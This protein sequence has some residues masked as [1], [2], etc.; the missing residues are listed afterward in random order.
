MSKDKGKKDQEFDDSHFA[1]HE[2]EFF[3]KGEVMH[4]PDDPN[5]PQ[6]IL[7]EE[8]PP[9]SDEDLQAQRSEYL[10][11]SSGRSSQ[12]E[13]Y[14]EEDED[15]DR[16]PFGYEPTNPGKAIT[17]IKAAAA[18][19]LVQQK[20]TDDDAIYLSIDTPRDVPATPE[21]PKLDNYSEGTKTNFVYAGLLNKITEIAKGYD[22]KLFFFYAKDLQA[23]PKKKCAIQEDGSEDVVTFVAKQLFMDPDPRI[24]Q[25][26]F[27]VD[28]WSLEDLKEYVHAEQ[29]KG[30]ALNDFITFCI[31]SEIE[32]LTQN[33]GQLENCINEIIEK[34]LS[35]LLRDMTEKMEK[36]DYELTERDQ[37]NIKKLIINIT[38]YPSLT[39]FLTYAVKQKNPVI[40]FFIEAVL[41]QRHEKKVAQK[42]SEFISTKFLNEF[43]ALFDAIEK[44]RKENGN[45]N[46]R[47]KT[48]PGI[49][50]KQV[51][52]GK[53][54]ATVPMAINPFNTNGIN[55]GGIIENPTTGSATTAQNE[56]RVIVDLGEEETSVP[57]EHVPETAQD[58]APAV[59]PEPVAEEPVAPAADP[60]PAAEEPVAPAADPE[61]VV[62]EVPAINPPQPAAKDK[63]VILSREVSSEIQLPS[64]MD[65]PDDLKVE[66]NNKFMKIAAYVS[67]A[68]IL[69][70]GGVLLSRKSREQKDKD[71]R[72]Q[73]AQKSPADAR[74]EIRQPVL[75]AL[76][77][78]VLPQTPDASVPQNASITPPTRPKE[79]QTP[80]PPE[81]TKV[82]LDLTKENLSLIAQTKEGRARLRKL[83]LDE[84]GMTKI[85]PQNFPLYNSFRLFYIYTPEDIPEGQNLYINGKKLAFSDN[86]WKDA[87]TGKKVY[88]YTNNLLEV[89]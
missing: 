63:G 74:V 18:E 72:P 56:S 22:G 46:K 65:E 68:V 34:K 62:A 79:D 27:P 66:R 64:L 44:R 45:G 31:Y 40:L 1:T 38:D 25:E 39:K 50:P 80:L 43:I 87:A 41:N 10:N 83:S 12:A 89:K 81:D 47:G 82:D 24:K 73:I 57:A 76:D 13:D 11:R 49:G 70:L 60:E 32:R 71:N 59:D 48:L 6:S 9:V 20:Q 7:P 75:S 88:F 29:G 77:A 5:F 21:K 16:N 26:F 53:N 54:E 17:D 84:N 4:T 14:Q 23:Y 78:E 28:M 35:M 15:Q 2:R 85:S 37:H 19:A 52:G 30:A 8:V 58:A 33:K 86:V 69:V 42:V 36:S 67:L 3:R 51:A 61:P 55:V